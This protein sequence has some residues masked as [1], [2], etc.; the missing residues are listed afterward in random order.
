MNSSLNFCFY[1]GSFFH[2]SVFFFSLIVLLIENVYS[3]WFWFGL[4]TGLFLFDIL[5]LLVY[6]STNHKI[7]GTTNRNYRIFFWSLFFTTSIFYFFILIPITVRLDTGLRFNEYMTTYIITNI[8]VFG[9]GIY[10]LLFSK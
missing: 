4:F 9:L 5:W 10:F 7:H 6:V 3:K 8:H 1:I 2:A